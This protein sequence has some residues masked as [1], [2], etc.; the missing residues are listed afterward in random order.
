M[1]H[2]TY[3]V[4]T[5]L[6]GHAAGPGDEV[7]FY[8]VS[9]DHLEHMVA[10]YPEVLPTHV[11]VDLGVDPETPN[12]RWDTVVQ[13]RRTYQMAL[14]A[15]ITNPY[16]HLRQYVVSSTLDPATDPAVT[17]VTDPV[18]TVRRLKAEPSEDG[19]LGVWLAGGGTL[20]GA[21]AD[22]IDELVVKV[23]PVLAGSGRPFLTGAFSPRTFELVDVSPPFRSGC[24]V[25]SYRRR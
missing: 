18:G 21:L 17:V 1:R 10:T 6:D 23:Y 4:G 5:T 7:D 12:L 20:A 3:Y 22:E 11:R 16:A 8:P 2:L 9:Q 25:M 24:V 14:D 15:G 13:G 19:G